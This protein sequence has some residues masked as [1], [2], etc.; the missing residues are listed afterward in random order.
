[1]D[2]D[3]TISITVKY[4]NKEHGGYVDIPPDKQNM[5]YIRTQCD[6]LAVSAERK[7][8]ALLFGPK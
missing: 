5:E 4:D 8:K 1:M 2:K 6:G 3:I 7:V